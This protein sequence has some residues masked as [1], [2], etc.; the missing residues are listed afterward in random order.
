MVT[1]GNAKENLKQ[2]AAQLAEL[3]VSAIDEKYAKRK[4][5][6][7]KPADTAEPTGD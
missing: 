5:R 4:K 3:L 2:A 6:E 1:D 7:R